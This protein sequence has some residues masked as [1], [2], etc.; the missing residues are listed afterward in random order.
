MERVRDRRAHFPSSGR[1]RAS[2]GLTHGAA[3]A[4]FGVLRAGGTRLQLLQIHRTFLELI[5]GLALLFIAG[6][7]ITRHLLARLAG[8]SRLPRP[9]TARPGAEV[10]RA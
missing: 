1:L 3:A 10:P 6:Q 8:P 4:F 9:S 2:G 5:Q 7:A